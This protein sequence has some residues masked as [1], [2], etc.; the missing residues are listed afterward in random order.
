M[1]KVLAGIKIQQEYACIQCGSLARNPERDEGATY[2]H[3]IICEAN[4]MV[5]LSEA[6]DIIWSLQPEFVVEEAT[7]ELDF[8]IDTEL[9]PQEWAELANFGVEGICYGS[10]DYLEGK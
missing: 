1:S 10:D 7:P 9:S 8:N 2:H 4:L 3:C 5:N 6:A